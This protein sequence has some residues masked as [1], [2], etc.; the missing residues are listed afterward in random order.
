MPNPKAL[1]F[2]VR[3]AGATAKGLRTLNPSNYVTFL[4]VFWARVF[5]PSGW[6]G[7]VDL[8][9]PTALMLDPSRA[10]MLKPLLGLHAYTSNNPNYPKYPSSNS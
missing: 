3:P 2:A 5:R 1:S 7:N 4:T 9:G 6:H 10:D 8:C